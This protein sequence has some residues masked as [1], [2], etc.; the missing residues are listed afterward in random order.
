[1]TGTTTFTATASAGATVEIWVDG[2]LAGRGNSVTWDSTGVED[3]TH[4]VTARAI[5]ADGDMV[6]SESYQFTVANVVVPTLSVAD[7]AVVE[8][9]T[10][11]KKIQVLFTL[12]E[13]TTKNV[14]ANFT[15]LD[16]TAVA[17]SDYST[18]SGTLYFPAG[19][20]QVAK[21]VPVVGETKIETDET[22]L[23]KATA[24]TGATLA[25]GTGTVTIEND[26]LP[27]AR[28]GIADLTVVEPDERVTVMV[29]VRFPTP[30]PAA[31]S[32][33]Y[34][35]QAGTAD[36]TDFIASTGTVRFAA[37]ATEVKIPVVI[38]GG[39]AKEASEYFTV[40]LTNPVGATI[41]DGT[42]KVTI[43]DD[44]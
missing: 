35:M 5:D 11:A 26:D 6:T 44:D 27:P 9:H 21:W 14:T 32:V 13:P 8:G 1:V 7:T 12:S 34:T 25:K 38:R 24:P 19:T 33:S 37:G 31:G 40:K 29:P 41:L 15:T 10:G 36:E 16:G 23:V 39:R 43:Q 18:L 3:G 20:T 22:F 2:A 42:A 17:G 30:A 28:I 4:S